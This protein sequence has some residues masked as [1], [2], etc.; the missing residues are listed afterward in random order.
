MNYNLSF[1]D[2][3]RRAQNVWKANFEAEHPAICWMWMVGG[4][5]ALRDDWS[6]MELSCRRCRAGRVES[7]PRAPS[8]T[9]D[10]C[11]VRVPASVLRQ[12]SKFERQPRARPITLIVESDRFAA[13]SVEGTVAAAGFS[14]GASFPDCLSAEKWLNTHSPDAAIIE[15]KLQDKA[16]VKLAKKLAVR[17]I[18][19]LALSGH[20]VGSPGVD[21]IFS[22]VLWLEKPVTS[23]GLQMALRSIL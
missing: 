12:D 19:F 3:A 2:D 9:G 20:A 6:I 17:E 23:A 1:L 11:I 14:V 8:E 5:C 18:P 7:C 21:R 22:P 15:V 13:K 16:C 4:V 10:C